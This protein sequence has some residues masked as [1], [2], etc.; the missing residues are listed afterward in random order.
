MSKRSKRGRGRPCK[1]PAL[2]KESAGLLARL[3]A[4]GATDEELAAAVG[5]SRATLRRRLD[6][7]PAFRVAIIQAKAEADEKVERALFERATGYQHPEERIFCHEGEIIRAETMRRY[8][9][10][11]IAC[12]FWLKNRRPAEWRDKQEIEHSG[13]VDLASVLKDARERMVGK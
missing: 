1:T 4:K 3:A 12:I 10:D 5:V 8:P 6:A 9:P 11:V 7:A 13:A 2:S